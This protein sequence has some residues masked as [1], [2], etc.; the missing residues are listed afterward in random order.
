MKINNY[1]LILFCL[2]LSQNIYG[3]GFLQ[4]ITK[5]ICDLS[6]REAVKSTIEFLSKYTAYPGSILVFLTLGSTAIVLGF[7]L[8]KGYN[9]IEEHEKREDDAVY[10][11]LSNLFNVLKHDDKIKIINN[12]NIYNIKELE[13]NEDYL[14]FYRHFNY[15]L[16]NKKKKDKYF[17]IMNSIK[18]KY[19]SFFKEF[20]WCKNTIVELFN[21]YKDYEYQP[22]SL[23]CFFYR[24]DLK[25]FFVKSEEDELADVDLQEYIEKINKIKKKEKSL[26]IIFKKLSL[27]ESA[28][29]HKDE[30]IESILKFL[31]INK[32]RLNDEL[33]CILNDI[34]ISK[35]KDLLIRKE[36]HLNDL[37]IKRREIE[38]FEEDYKKFKENNKYI[39]DVENNLELV[40]K[41]FENKENKNSICLYHNPGLKLNIGQ[42]KE[43]LVCFYDKLIKLDINNFESQS[44]KTPI[45]GLLIIFNNNN[46]NNCFE[47]QKNLGLYNSWKILILKYFELEDSQIKM[48]NKFIKECNDKSK[49]K[50][51]EKN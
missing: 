19:I 41:N 32:E 4:R 51:L 12:L 38:I 3:D 44:Y 5:S 18:D 28:V 6:K 39:Q 14:L 31:N 33:F 40:L 2:I 43:E 20:E 16:E 23:L 37:I 9:I 8:K 13:D 49:E 34:V 47:E 17:A 11:E 35:M 1:F 46:Y 29:I 25:E 30:Q 27:D 10:D 21:N 15:L 50:Y 36:T 45:T 26:F 42:S 22:K 48:V 7:V 24:D